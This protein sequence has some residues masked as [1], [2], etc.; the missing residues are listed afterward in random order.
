MRKLEQALAAL[1]KEPPR[2]P[3]DLGQIAVA[4]ALGWLEFRGFTPDLAKTHASLHAWFNEFR[5]RPSM[6][7]TEPKES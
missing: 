5:A 6:R 1:A 2:G 3:L 7:A 4:C